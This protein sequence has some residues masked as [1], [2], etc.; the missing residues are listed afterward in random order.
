M[1]RPLAYERLAA[2]LPSAKTKPNRR[3]VQR[4]LDARWVRPQLLDNGSGFVIVREEE[5]HADDAGQDRLPA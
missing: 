4:E 5:L 1:H 2:T 3:I